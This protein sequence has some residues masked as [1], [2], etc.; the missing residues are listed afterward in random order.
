MSINVV[1]EYATSGRLRYFFERIAN[2]FG[3]L[4][5]LVGLFAAIVFIVFLA[6]VVIPLVEE[7]SM[8]DSTDLEPYVALAVSLALAVVCLILGRRLARGKRR[9]ILFLRH[10]GFNK[11]TQALTFALATVI[12]RSWY[13]VTLDD[14]EVTPMGVRKGV[15]GSSIVVGIIAFMIVA[16]LLYWIFGGGLMNM[17][18][19]AAGQ[20]NLDLGAAIGAAIASAFAILIFGALA[21]FGVTIFAPVAIFS[22][23][24]N[25]I[26]RRAEQSK[27]VEI[28]ETRKIEPAAHLF[29]RQGRRIFGP[30]LMVARVASAIWQEVVS[31]IATES[32]SV[33]IDISEPTESL[34]W[35]VTTLKPQFG[36]HWILVGE[37][38]RLN[39]MAT[40]IP[41]QHSP[42]DQRLLD[43][44]DGED[45]LA[46]S[47]ERSSRK[48]FARALRARLISLSTRH[49]E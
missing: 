40:A 26:V 47:S 3:F 13:V 36:S 22:W 32:S 16:A 17:G 4:L 15:R 23:W 35:E 8:P 12:G 37:R 11:A 41:G 9:L 31:R 44:L 7:G 24:I 20:S 33:V 48:R 29:S 39:N 45:V 46:Y 38:D 49:L 19:E 6:I 30:K 27:T 10:F 28:S 2:L 5:I 18:E 25:A 21:L 14:A 1:D 42:I 34:L 43:L